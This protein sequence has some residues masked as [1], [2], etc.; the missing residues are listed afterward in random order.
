MAGALRIV[1]HSFARAVAGALKARCG[2]RE[3]DR[4]LLAVSGGADSVAMLR[5]IAPLAGR[6]TWKLGLGVGHVQHHLRADEHAEGD[7]ALVEALAK[8][9]GLP[10]CRADLKKPARKENAE[11]WARRERYLALAEMARACRATAIV[12]AHHADDQLETLLMRL[13]RGASIRGLQGMAWRRRLAPSGEDDPGVSILRPML[14]VDR[15]AVEGFLRDIRQPWREDHTNADVSRLRARLRRDVLPGLRAASPHAGRRAVQ[16]GDHLRDVERVVD[17]AA[18]R[19]LT[20]AREVNGVWTL[21]RDEAR[22]WPRV[23]LAAALRQVLQNAGVGADQLGTRPLA[24]LTRAVRD[25]EGG[26][27]RF[28]FG[29]RVIAVVTR[30]VVEVWRK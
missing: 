24:A 10:F 17:T 3:G 23:V 25:R 4:L 14:A 18:A 22:F 20:S 5:A 16:L 30:E 8:Q 6:R 9:L 11:A 2:I 27:R 1:E 21:P 29:N 7:A 28:E 15:A 12:T 19:A 13:M 26:R